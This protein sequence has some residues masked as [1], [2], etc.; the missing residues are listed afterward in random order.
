MTLPTRSLRGRPDL[1]QLKRQARELLQA[2]RAG[3]AAAV[4][5][6]R[7]HERAPDAAS[8]ALHDAQRVLARAYGFES[9]AKLKAYVDGVNTTRLGDA[10]E[11]GDVT[12]VRDVLRRRPELINMERPGHGEQRALHVAVLNADEPMVRVLLE[13][14]AD[15]HI[16]IY[17]H[18]DATSAYV[19]A[20]D[21]GLDGIVA[22]IEE[23]D[24]ARREAM[25]CPNATVSPAQDELNAAIR[26]C[27]PQGD[28]QALAL[29]EADASLIKACDRDGRTPLHVA[30]EVLN[31]TMVRRLLEHRADVK[32]RDTQERTP[33]DLAVGSG[34][35]DGPDAQAFA[36]VAG[37]LRGRG[38]ELT[39]RAAVAL[40]EADWLRARH[41]EDALTNPIDPPGGLLTIAVR[42]DRPDMLALLLEMG[43]DP[44]ERM[45]VA[46]VEAT[47]ESWGMP[48]WHCA[49][50]GRY[51][52]AQM[53]LD[54]SADPNG[55]VYASGSPVFQAYG[56]RDQRMI[57][58]LKRHGGRA[59]A[60]TVGKHGEMEL[61]R[62]ML[63]ANDRAA[64]DE[65]HF[66]GEHVAEQMLW[67]A[68]GS[69][70]AELVRLALEH[71]DRPPDDPHWFTMLEQP[72]RCGDH[73][74]A[75]ACFRLILARCDP[76]IRSRFNVVMLHRALGRYG[77]S[78][79]PHDDAGRA[80]FVR[81][82]LEAGA[83]TDV[84]DTLL[85]ST[86]L[87]WACRWGRLEPAALL[88]EHGAP[89]VEPD[90]Q[91]W[92]QPLAWATKGKHHRIV[93]LLRHHG[94]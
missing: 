70:H 36:A 17:P 11:R 94:A 48:L 93:Q 69:G 80:A 83:S 32:R 24:R 26:A 54:R 60:I 45:R 90:A 12:T 39:A 9:W 1:E 56:A 20:R 88:L 66:A 6:V 7:C 47:I 49:K 23:A 22:L 15:G 46:G 53:L 3:D 8:F 79:F 50:H 59:D 44:D 43:F 2:F 18:R 67:G 14:D 74:A 16:G 75:V 84:R 52:M 13:H 85:Q 58:L 78:D 71:V 37:L 81:L 40:G 35:G 55:Q 64:V 86:P 92:A 87:G 65:G 91:P 73:D 27:T 19:M 34:W 42:H 72:L 63:A 28:A 38:A 89:A 5:E 68:A 30:C 77:R 31:E 51:D 62:E 21:R 10:V 82:L 76:D 61:A 29:L 4:A 57:E 41:A 25:S 33:L